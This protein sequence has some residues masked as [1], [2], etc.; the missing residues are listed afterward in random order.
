MSDMNF[1]ELQQIVSVCLDEIVKLKEENASLKQELESQN[2]T[3]NALFNL[4][5]KVSE[6]AMESDKTADLK[7]NALVSALD[8]LK[9]EIGG[10]TLD[11]KMFYP[12]IADID[13]TV[14][15]I[16]AE[17]K[18]MAR[19][20]D[21]EFAIM[22]GYTRHGFQAYD[23]KLSK[24][25]NEIISSNADKFLIAIG[26]YFGKLEGYNQ[27]SKQE[28]R[29]FMSEENRRQVLG[30]LEA[31]R[32]YH[33]TFIT[34]PY[35]MYADNHT[36]G[37]RKRFDSLK[38]IW[39]KRNVIFVEGEETRLG[40]GNDLFDN[41]NSIKRII[42]PAKSSFSKYDSILEASL[43]YA[44]TDTL[45]LIALGPTAGVL[46]YDLFTNGY[47]AIDIGHL[48]LEYEWMLNGTGGRSEVKTKY[49]NEFPGGDVVEAVADE[50]YFNEIVWKYK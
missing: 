43:K 34:R 27:N 47:Q 41:A 48:D 26:N 32:Q 4:V 35:A 11:E 37:P 24:R 13:T 21:G 50:K 5:K 22:L 46:A 9:Y 7:Y 8:N 25:L 29:A 10:F 2:S 17:K 15:E 31:D 36:D 45:F 28:I 33:N 1:D 40:V 38:R 20:G 30:L 12:N 44:D 14:Q 18:S 49:N 6:S 16:V 19:F 39:D 42:C 3:V 23:D